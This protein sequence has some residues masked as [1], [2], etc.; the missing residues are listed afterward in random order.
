M[1]L[2]DFNYEHACRFRQCTHCFVLWIKHQFQDNFSQISCSC[3]L[4]GVI[5]T[6][7]IIKVTAFALGQLHMHRLQGYQM[8][9]FNLWVGGIRMHLRNTFG[10]RCLNFK[11]CYYHEDMGLW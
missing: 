9:I 2:Y 4:N 7:E 8:S 3:P 1:F 10:L 11:L 6:L 5:R